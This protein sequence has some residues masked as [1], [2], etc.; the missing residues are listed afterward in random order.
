MSDN[1][2]QQ[3]KQLSDDYRR[4]APAGLLGDVKAEMSRRGV[5]SRPDAVP[6]ARRM[7]PARRWVAAAAVVALVGG[8]AVLGLWPDGSKRV[9]QSP[10]STAQSHDAGRHL[11]EERGV[12]EGRFSVHEV[13]GVG[14]AR[15][16]MADNSEQALAVVAATTITTPSDTLPAAGGTATQGEATAN[17]T[18]TE[19]G[20]P[21]GTPAQRKDDASLLAT[22]EVY[23]P[24][25]KRDWQ[26]GV[27]YGNMGGMPNLGSGGEPLAFADA[28]PYNNEYIPYN[29]SMLA[30]LP[31]T[32]KNERHHRPVRVSLS[33]SRRFAPRWS[34]QSGLTYSYLRSE[35]TT[36]QGN[37][38]SDTSQKLH[39]LGI[40]VTV[41]YS[42]WNTRKLNVYA[43]GGGMAELLVKGS[44]QTLPTLSGNKLP[45]TTEHVSDH[46]PVFSVQGGV[47]VEYQLTRHLGIY[48][49]PGMSYYFDN[50]GQVR[51]SYTDK[52]F[53]LNL[54]IGVRL[55]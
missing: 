9:A 30:A 43:T 40:P 6:S 25:A 23:R 16:T 32:V 1:W 3:L 27:A 53:N 28:A 50:G 20:R 5:L 34:L 55:K 26:V 42:V 54:N 24:T 11:A 22:A 46:R 47:G 12:T 52:P 35:F 51:S 44:A 10:V 36:Q 33:V 2:K 39:Y 7:S 21:I 17:K 49:E 48:V 38:T 15:Q 31:P 41:S 4:Q 29:T 18:V 14:G 13:G 8:V 45:Q 19:Y 37:L